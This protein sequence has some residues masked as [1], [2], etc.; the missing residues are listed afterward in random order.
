MTKRRFGAFLSCGI[1]AIALS[2][3]VDVQPRDLSDADWNAIKQNARI[4]GAE[5]TQVSGEVGIVEYG[6]GLRNYVICE[7][8]EGNRGSRRKPSLDI[9]TTVVGAD[10]G[11]FLNSQNVVTY[12]GRTISFDEESV[13][14]FSDGTTCRSSGAFEMRL[15]GKT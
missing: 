15:V 1:A 3:C 6:G 11:V 4:I 7:Y 14:E 13:G 2:A 9:R 5:A 12:K 8:A 10:G